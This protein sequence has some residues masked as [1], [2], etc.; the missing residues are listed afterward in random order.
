[1]EKAVAVPPAQRIPMMRIFFRF[2]S[3]RD[4]VSGMGKMRMARSLMTLRMESQRIMISD[5]MPV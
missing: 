5:K 2:E 3:S 1:M 4:Q